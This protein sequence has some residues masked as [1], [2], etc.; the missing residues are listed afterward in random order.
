V[1]DS[2]RRLILWPRSTTNNALFSLSAGK[3][4]SSVMKGSSGCIGGQPGGELVLFDDCAAAAEAGAITS[5][6]TWTEGGH[7]M[8]GGYCVTADLNGTH[9]GGGRRT[10]DG[11]FLF[12]VVE[13]PT[14]QTNLINA[15]AQVERV[16]TMAH[17]L[18][19]S[20]VMTCG[21]VS[22]P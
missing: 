22:F 17:T 10:G 13:D 2:A 20:P 7:M 21:N 6:F 8:S 4:S 1:Q 12:N 15:S 5:N 16:A 18:Q 3:I 11:A 19:V 9:S 14:E